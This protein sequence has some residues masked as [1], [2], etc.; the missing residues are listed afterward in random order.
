MK[1]RPVVAELLYSNRQTDEPK[2]I[3][4]FRTFV[5]ALKN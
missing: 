2:L 5:I 3:V 4:P 1:I